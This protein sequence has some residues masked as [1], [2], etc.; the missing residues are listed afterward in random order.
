MSA[1]TTPISFTANTLIRSA[2]VNTNFTNINTVVN[3][4]IDNTNISASA[5]IARS[6][7]A[8]GTAYRIVANTSAGVMSE[9]AALTAS[10]VVL[11]DANGQLTTGTPSVDQGGTGATTLTNHG[12]LLGQ[13]TSAIAATSA[14]TQ[15]QSL[16][17]GGASADPAFAAISLGQAAAV[18]GQLPIGNGGTGASTAAGAMSAISPITTTGDLIY[19]SSGTTNSRLGIGSAGQ[20]LRVSGGIPAWQSSAA[21]N[22]AVTTKTASYTITSSDDIILGN[23]NA[24]TLTLPAASSNSGKVFVIKK[25]GSDTNA[26]TVARA[27][28]DTIDGVTSLV[29]TTQYDYVQIIS[30]GSATWEVV[31]GLSRVLVTAYG[32]TTSCAS[33]ATVDVVW[34]TESVDSHAAFDGTTFTA[35]KA[36]V[37]QLSAQVLTAGSAG[38][39]GGYTFQLVLNGTTTGSYFVPHSQASANMALV[40]SRIV[41]L[42]SGDTIKMKYNQNTGNTEALSGND[43]NTWFTITSF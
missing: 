32:S 3:G 38:T 26:V 33:G 16:V 1:I 29:L 9:N 5:S 20:Y 6:K 17:S 24:I 41:K 34:S 18:S 21:A 28:S 42:A 19:S 40:Y 15:Y 4:N 39:S 31:S 7:L 25:I 8:S 10:K 30:D 37:Y 12:V 36:G 43:N 11:S 13:A 2:D 27:G 22:L 14:G 35:P 23:T